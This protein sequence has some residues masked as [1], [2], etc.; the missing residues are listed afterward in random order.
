M[1]AADQGNNS[2]QLDLKILTLNI[3]GLRKKTSFLR[4]IIHKYKPDIVCLQE[5][6]ISDNYS[7]NKAIYELGLKSE[8]CF[9]NY[10][11]TKSNGTAILCISSVFKINNAEYF[12]EGR[13]IILQIQINEI[14]YTIVNVYAPTNP[15]QRHHYFNELFTQLESTRNSKNLII[16]GDFNI[17]LEEIDITGESGNQRI[18]RIELKNLVDI[19]K[20]NDAF[21]IKHPFQRETTF[22]NKT[23]NRSA[24][25]DRIYFSENIPIV[26]AFHIASSLD[27]TDHKGVLAHFSN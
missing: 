20:L 25:L 17:T 6:N 11:S 9:F 26:N 14:N 21:R 5:T 23:H 19:L 2:L 1:A 12:D 22:E 18:G 10:P 16:A 13:S 7:M 15:T 8:N 24:R 4:H 27:F 3:S